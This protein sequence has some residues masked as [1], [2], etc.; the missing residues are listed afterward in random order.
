M[1][2]LLDSQT[3][4]NERYVIGGP[5]GQGGMG[6]V[7]RA[8]DIL[9][10]GR[11]CAIKEIAPDPDADDGALIQLQDQFRREASVLARL[12]H[13]NLP[14]VSDYF[15][16]NGREYLVMDYV[17][18]HNL[19]ELVDKALTDQGFLDEAT[20]LGWAK[21]L[22][23]AIAFLHSQDPPVLHR[24]VKPSNIKLTPS[25][26]LK[27][28]DFGLVK[29]LTSDEAR[30]VTVVQGQGTAAYT[31]LE[32]YGGD[33]THTDTRTDVYALGATLYHLLTGRPPA[34]ARERFLRPSAL[35][36]PR[37][38][39]PRV[40][41]GVERAILEA[42]ELHPRDRPATI[43]ELARALDRAQLPSSLAPLVLT[44]DEIRSA[45]QRNLPLLVALAV[46]LVIAVLVTP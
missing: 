16:Q 18:G 27:L 12:D 8:E 11:V 46:L 13:P 21:Q 22:C 3:L 44:P 5:I 10:S 9:L 45:W 39:N 28:V 6:A 37:E 36:P 40:S 19:R 29:L 14:K 34:T 26:L 2:K 35:V 17:P 15:T 4:L 20:V 1:V 43:G 25:G 24:D 38:L 31:P 33:D 7:Y 23:D 42:L 32:Q 41:P 30:T